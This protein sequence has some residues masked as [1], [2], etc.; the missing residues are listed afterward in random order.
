MEPEIVLDVRGITK[1]IKNDVLV[2][3]LSFQMK[4]GEIVGLLG[5]NGA[6]KTTTM[7]M[8]VG[9]MHITEGDAFIAGYS[10]RSELQQALARAG[11]MVEAPSFYP[12]FSGYDNLAYYARMAEDVDAARIDEVVHLVGLTQAIHKRVKTYSLGMKQRLGIA[13]AL[14]HKPSVLILDEP[15]NGLDP[16]GIREMRNYVKHIAKEEGTAILVSSHLLAEIELMCERVIIIQNG[17]CI[18]QYS[19]SDMPKYTAFQVQNAERASV[20]LAESFQLKSED[21]HIEERT[22][23]V[24]VSEEQI[25]AIVRLLVQH[26]IN[27]YGIM[28]VKKNLEDM[29]LEMT[30]GNIIV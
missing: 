1:K 28:P 6:G 18:E 16:A 4:K 24:P 3:N 2:Q 10:V 19:L 23:I 13:Q 26:E 21:L 8:L 30:G 17:T 15:T 27:V 20:I 12:F 5:P 14:L 11:V 29:F 25:P 9:L 22:L 7:K